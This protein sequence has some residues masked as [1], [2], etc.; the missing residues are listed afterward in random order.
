MYTQF[1]IP[2]LIKMSA[3]DWSMTRA[4]QTHTHAPGL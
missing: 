1:I 3:V 4:Y 2:G